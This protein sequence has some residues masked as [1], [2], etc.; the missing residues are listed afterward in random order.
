MGLRPFKY[1]IRDVSGLV[2]LHLDRMES[3]S[4]YASRYQNAWVASAKLLVSYAE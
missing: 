1:R 2:Q 4:H 3:S